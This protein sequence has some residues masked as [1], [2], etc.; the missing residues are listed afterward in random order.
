[1]T[2]NCR[3]EYAFNNDEV[4]L[5]LKGHGQYKVSF[6]S[7]TSSVAPTDW[8]KLIPEI[9][10][11]YEDTLNKQIMIKYED[12]IYNLFLGKIED[13]YIAT[14]VLYFQILREENNR[15]PFTIN[16]NRLLDKVSLAINKILEADDLNNTYVSEILRYRRLLKDKFNIII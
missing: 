7:F 10:R 8:T 12:A 2:H 4:E 13:I 9:Y 16:R 6:D 1:M 3:V 5:L 15:A 11:L 14:S